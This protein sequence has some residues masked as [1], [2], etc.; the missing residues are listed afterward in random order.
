MHLCVIVAYAIKL[1]VVQFVKTASVFRGGFYASRRENS[2]HKPFMSVA[3]QV[4]LLESRNLVTNSRT[5]WVL[6]REGYYSIVNGYKS[7]FLDDLKSRETGDDRYRE[8]VSFD[9]IYALF[10]FDRNL[11]FL[12]FR[13][14]TL[15]EAILK[16]VCSH[17]FTKL[18]P[19]EKN[20]YLN[21]ANYA[22]TGTAH[23]K[24]KKLIPRLEKIPQLNA[25]SGYTDQ[26]DYLRH[27]MEHH[28][29]EVPLWVLANDLTLG[30]MYWFFQSQK[31]EARANI[32][33]S[34][35]ALYADSHKHDVEVTSQ[36]LDKIYRRIKDYRNIC[37][38]DERLYCA[39][40][41]DLNIT[42]FQLAQDL[43]FVTDKQR[44]LE[45]L[46]GFDSLLMRLRDDIPV[47]FDAVCK[48]IG[49]AYP[50][51]LHSDM[52]QIRES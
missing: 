41:H 47:Y 36:R 46:Q 6:E 39:H 38:H 43:R 28:D 32:A 25:E 27:C 2:M 9:N 52:Q 5:G 26:K 14:T 48:E 1:G 49:M 15:A 51:D 45:F 13:M 20:P 7:P 16:T 29:G 50:N 21:I 35:T 24:A 4:K 11:R 31:T 40:P 8:N 33:R 30:Q 42:V 23:E 3:D 44:Y 18:N 34:F 19:G 37:A 10:V 12:F 17:E 22:D